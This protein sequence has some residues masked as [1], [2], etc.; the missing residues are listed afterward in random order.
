M[1]GAAEVKSHPW[2]KDFDWEALRTKTMKP[3]YIPD[4]QKENFD[5]NHVNNK[6]WNDTEEVLEYSQILKRASQKEVFKQYYFDKQS[7]VMT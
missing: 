4:K 1:Q 2:F 3:T 5:D 6:G 7:N